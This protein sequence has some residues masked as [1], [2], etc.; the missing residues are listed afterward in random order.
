MS[1]GVYSLLA[2]IYTFFAESQAGCVPEWEE[3]SQ[4]GM[5]QPAFTA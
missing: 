2:G 4:V 3:Q 5:N 1:D